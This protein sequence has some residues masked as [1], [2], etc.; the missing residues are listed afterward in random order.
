MVILAANPS[1]T[2]RATVLRR[3]YLLDNGMEDASATTYL[4]LGRGRLFRVPPVGGLYTQEGVDPAIVPE[5]LKHYGA[6]IE[7]M[8]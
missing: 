1:H 3:Q 2:L 5:W 6:T 8:I 4:L 7:E